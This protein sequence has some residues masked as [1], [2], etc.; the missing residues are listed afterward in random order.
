MQTELISEAGKTLSLLGAS[1]GGIA[2]KE[3]LSPDERAVIA[4]KAAEARW[5]KVATHAGVLR[6]GID[7]HSIEIPCLVLEDGTRVITGRGMTSAIGMKGRGQ[8]MARIVEHRAL[9]PFISEELRLAIENPIKLPGSGSRKVNP[10]SGYEATVLLRICDSILDARRAGALK[11][12]QECRYADCCEILVKAF[13]KVGIIALVDEATGYQ[14]D[15]AKDALE[16]ILASFI[17]E[18]LSRWAKRFPDAF[19]Q[20]LFRLKGL[21]WPSQKNPPQFIGH[22]TNN[23]VYRRIAPGV[24]AELQQ[25]TPKDNR[26]RRQHR[27]HQWLTEDVGHPKLQ[28]H[29]SAVLALMRASDD[30]ATFEKMLNRSLP[31]QPQTATERAQTHFGFDEADDPKVTIPTGE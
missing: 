9:K 20:E 29:I 7:D 12:I 4:K 18:E 25:K 16:R 23:I 22:L 28:E 14:A 19:Y 6:I 15:R 5:G 17:S 27:F 1:K 31:K 13:A 30:W 26:G 10:T 24:L 3:K 11:T 2:R 21:K 8:G